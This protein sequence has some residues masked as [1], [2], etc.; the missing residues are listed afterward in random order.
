MDSSKI[1]FSFKETEPNMGTFATRVIHFLKV[2]DPRKFFV[3]DQEI[4]DGVALVKKFKAEADKSADGV[5]YV[6]QQE[7][8]QIIQGIE[9]MNSSTNDVGDL[10]PKPFRMCG[11]VPVNIPILCGIVLSKPTMFNTIFF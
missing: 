6:S 3:S 8:A 4:I 10:V 11:F 5:I 2:T 9:N 7:K 1:A